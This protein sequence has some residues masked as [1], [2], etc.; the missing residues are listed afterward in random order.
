MT[1]TSSVVLPP[2]H[3]FTGMDVPSALAARAERFGDRPFL[4]W[5]P[6]VGTSGRTWTYGELAAEVDV[7]A[8]GLAA[9][10]VGR[11]DPVLVLLEN[12]PAFLLTWFA[13]ARLGAV[14]V[15]TNTRFATEEL[16]YALDK[17]GA[18]GIVTH[19]HLVERVQPV[20]GDR[21]LVT[22]D[23]ASATCLALAGDPGSV[24]ER[25][26][27]PGAA[28]CVQFTSGTTSR[29]KAVLYTHANALWGARVGAS[30]AHLGPDDVVLVYAPL[31]HTAALSWQTLAT[32]WVGGTVVLLP[33]YTASRFWEISL[34]HRCT[35]TNLL[36][37]TIQTLSAQPVPE[38]S[39]RSWQFGREVPAL[40]DRY[41]VRLLN[42]WGMTE[43]VTNVVVG[44][45]GFP[46]EPGAIGRVTPEYTGRV[47]RADGTD[48][49]VGEPGELVV[50]G[51]RG[52]SLFAEYVDDPDATAEAFDGQGGF[53]T[54]DVVRLLPGGAI[55]F[56]NR[57][58][59]MLKVGGE[60]VASAEIERVLMALPGVVGAAVVGRRDPILDEVPVAF[61]VARDVGDPTS[62]A[63]DAIAH[64]RAHLADFKVP[65]AVHLVDELP[66]SM[67]GKINKHALR[68]RIEP[69]EAPLPR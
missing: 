8:A 5:E 24:P 17:T 47:V 9:R 67:L 37:I 51:V 48:A 15:D 18:V 26:P 7:V 33:K 43:V 55:Q 63:D 4:V 62:F 6:G 30:H 19:E 36:G 40:E 57:A 28:L 41:G 29:P 46:D 22:I 66:E 32:F 16:R 58:K 53:R 35:H 54:G 44:D 65:R 59:D 1:I 27:D 64:C 12:S 42:C 23:E 20:V 11:G 39:Y 2:L 34:R 13:C 45:L 49:D 25:I 56:V 14:A 68:E 60:N 52:L 38:H 69:A 50:G 31:F 61:L 3:P 10:G 21:W